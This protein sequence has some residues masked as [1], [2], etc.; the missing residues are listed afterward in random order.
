ML[1]EDGPEDVIFHRTFAKV[2]ENGSNAHREKHKTP[3]P[4]DPDGKEIES[5]RL[6]PVPP[7]VAQNED[8]AMDNAIIDFQTTMH[9][10]PAL[11]LTLKKTLNT[12][13]T[14]DVTTHKKTTNTPLNLTKTGSTTLVKVNTC[15]TAQHVQIFHQNKTKTFT[16]AVRLSHERVMSRGGLQEELS[17]YDNSYCIPS[18]RYPTWQVSTVRWGEGRGMREGEK[19]EASRGFEDSCASSRG[20]LT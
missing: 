14:T 3:P 19:V 16:P 2:I 12:V 10:I 18:R 17:F 20:G 8:N 15:K 13:L 9:A 6:S 1:P 11:D 5:S 4:A 7:T